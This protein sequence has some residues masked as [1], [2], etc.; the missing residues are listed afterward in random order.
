MSM[1]K[2]PYYTVIV[3]NDYHTAEQQLEDATQPSLLLLN[4]ELS[5]AIGVQMFAEICDELRIKLPEKEFV[6]AYVAY[7]NVGKIMQG[8]LTSIDVFFADEKLANYEELK[9]LLCKHGKMLFNLQQ[10]ADIL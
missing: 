1:S 8:A 5:H 9:K 7:H 3:A 4:P 10:L 6:A 2:L